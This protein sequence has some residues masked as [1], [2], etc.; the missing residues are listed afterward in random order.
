MTCIVEY[1]TGILLLNIN[2]FSLGTFIVQIFIDFKRYQCKYPIQ[3]EPFSRPLPPANHATHARC[4]RDAP[5]SYRE[6]L[7]PHCC[8]F[9]PSGQL[10]N[11][12]LFCYRCCGPCSPAR[13]P[14][15]ASRS[16]SLG[17]TQTRSSRTPWTR[18]WRRV[19]LRIWPTLLESLEKPSVPWRPVRWPSSSST[20]VPP[21]CRL[22]SS[23]PP[24]AASPGPS[25]RF[26]T[27]TSALEETPTPSASRRSL[28]SRLLQ[29]PLADS[30]HRPV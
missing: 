28:S 7:C 1:S 24:P 18:S 19:W 11:L 10:S 5:Y 16:P 22:A 23:L 15:P 9:Y 13:A 27:T 25:C 30:D 20:P 12:S 2:H 8:V 21:P 29:H 26:Q 6:T 14:A 3:Y 17:T 4:R